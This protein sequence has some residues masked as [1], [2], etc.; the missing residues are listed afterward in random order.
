[1]AETAPTN[2]DDMVLKLLLCVAAVAVLWVCY[3]CKTTPSSTRF[4]MLKYAHEMGA[5]LHAPPSP[6]ALACFS[7]TVV[8]FVFGGVALMLYFGLDFRL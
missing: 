4:P 5:A 1:M 2:P 6:F 3:P 7:A 8:A